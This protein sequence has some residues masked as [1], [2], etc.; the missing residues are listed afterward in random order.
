MESKYKIPPFLKRDNES[1]IFNNDGYFVF[2][3]PEVYFERKFAEIVGE[4]VNIMGLL[5]YAIF[6]EKEQHDG[7]RTFNY[8]TM[9]TTIPKK[10][11]KIKNIKLTKTSDEAD[12]RL[13][14]YEKGDVIV[15]SVML[16]QKVINADT[17]FGMFMTGKLPTTLDY[18]NIHNLFIDNIKLNG[19]D[20]KLNAQLFGI[21][22]AK[23]C[24]SKD[25][26]KTLF[27][28]TNITDMTDYKYISMKQIPKFIS[29][30]A[31]MTS[32]NIDDSI[33]NSTLVK[34]AKYSPLE[35]IM[36]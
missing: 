6:N 30:F 11:E 15:K 12:Y 5:N 24:R 23:M 18:S 8:P 31:S 36:I 1:L 33:I 2:Y 10:I 27:R 28:H 20:Y 25:D 35:K 16:E 4:N 22:V 26:I 19:E 32:E 9:F 13:F 3:V 29:P 7:L 14:K 17:L 21:L 34:N